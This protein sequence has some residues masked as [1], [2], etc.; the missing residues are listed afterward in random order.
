MICRRVLT[1]DNGEMALRLVM[2]EGGARAVVWNGAKRSLSYRNFV[3]YVLHNTSAGHHGDWHQLEAKVKEHAW[4]P[5][6]ADDCRRWCK[7]CHTC[8]SVKATARRSSAWRSERYTAPMRCL[9]IDLVGPVNAGTD[10]EYRYAMTVIDMFSYWLWVVPMR[11]NSG[12]EI[13]ETLHLH[14]FSDLGGWPAVLRSDR[15][16][17]TADVFKELNER[18]GV[19]QVFGSAYHPRGQSLVE[20]SHRGLNDTLK[21]WSAKTRTG[22]TESCH[23]SVGAGTPRARKRLEGCPLTR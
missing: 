9:A 22:G 21:R 7:R 15:G 13:A 1:L 20:R 17:F 11:T 6:L 16:E 2:P 23:C 5:G 12:R 19:R 14:V 10:T 8:R 4:W 18:L 3:L